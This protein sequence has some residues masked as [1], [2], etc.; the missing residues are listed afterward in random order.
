MA[1]QLRFGERLSQQLGGRSRFG[2][3]VDARQQ[4]DVAV[5][6]FYQLDVAVELFYASKE[7][8]N[9]DSGGFLDDGT[10]VVPFYLRGVHRKHG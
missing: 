3:V 8:A 9:R 7:C 10:D 2:A 5:E 4:L 6:L 1:R